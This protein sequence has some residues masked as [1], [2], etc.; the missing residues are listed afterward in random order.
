MIEIKTY[1]N[2]QRHLQAFKEK[3][4]NLLTIVGKGGIGKTFISEDTL[5][6][7]APL[8]FT[9]HVTPLSMYK[10]LYERNR[11]EKDFLVIFDDVDSLL[12]NKTNVALLKQLCDTREIKT[13]KYS[14]SSP[15]LDVPKEFETK[16][17]ILM[18]VNELTHEDKNIS[19]LLTRS[20]LV[21]FIPN[22]LEILK[23]IKAFGEDNEII[24][25]IEIYAAFSNKLNLRVY[26][27]AVELK[28]SKL[29]WQRS[30]VNDLQVD[31][32]LLEMYK[33][34]KKYKT[35]KEREKHFS[36]SRATYYRCK[37]K[38]LSKNPTLI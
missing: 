22:D 26:K 16:C 18:L 21:N 27:R 25:F 34:L 29:D 11:E 19:A 30:I 38:L 35:D 33:L 12:L 32:K 31:E 13:L 5:I 9:G 20:H 36:E 14:S 15:S 8:T 7:E 37:K 24:K 28:D 23:N 17:K 4:L 1:K 2:L 6:E 10:E 3:K